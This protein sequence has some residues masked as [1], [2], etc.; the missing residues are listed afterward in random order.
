MGRRFTPAKVLISCIV[1]SIFI[2]LLLLFSFS[3]RISGQPE[4]QGYLVSVSTT[5]EAFFGEELVRTVTKAAGKW[6]MIMGMSNDSI[7]TNLLVVSATGETMKALATELRAIPYVRDVRFAGFSDPAGTGE[8]TEVRRLLRGLELDPDKVN[9]RQLSLFLSTRLAG[10]YAYFIVS[11]HQRNKKG[12]FTMYIK[13][14]EELPTA[15]HMGEVDSTSTV[16][17]MV[18]GSDTEEVVRGVVI[19]HV[20]EEEPPP[21][22]P[23]PPNIAM[24]KMTDAQIKSWFRRNDSRHPGSKRILIKRTPDS[25]LITIL[26]PRTTETLSFP[27]RP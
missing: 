3:P 14:R 1:L 7:K 20:V 26:L 15:S 8:L 12:L 5:G 4:K 9:D 2:S 19:S 24:G 27:K 23:P 16:R 11:D 18:H 17:Y 13:R 10:E 22:P 25:V 21:P 6:Q